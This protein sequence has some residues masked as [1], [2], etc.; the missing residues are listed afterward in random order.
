M[1]HSFGA[2]LPEPLKSVLD[3]L[4]NG[5][6]LHTQR[7]CSEAKSLARLF[8]LDFEP[9]EVAAAAHDICRAMNGKDLL[10]EAQRRRLPINEI[11]QHLPILLHG[12]LAAAIVRDEFGMTDKDL[13]QA[14]HWHST[15]T[16]G[17]HPLAEL[18]FLADKLDPMKKARYPFIDDV[19][20]C[21]IKDYEKAS[22]LFISE[23]IKRLVSS[24]QLLHPSS[25][26]TRNCLLERFL[27]RSAQ[28][29]PVV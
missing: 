29:G 3:K 26:A 4:P 2:R 17:M 1:D 14:I 5:L 11:E 8:G 9:V 10:S 12:P 7:V 15:G 28:A 16:P 24:G 23:D 19:R 18:I 6:Y 25:V 20:E 27:I 13:L 22:F 21:L